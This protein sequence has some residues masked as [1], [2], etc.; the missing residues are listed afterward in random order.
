MENNQ[1]MVPKFSVKKV[2]VFFL[3]WGSYVVSCCRVF[4]LWT[5]SLPF[6]IGAMM[7]VG[8]AFCVSV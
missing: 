7:P 8:I 3:V 5:F 6:N 2:P 1:A 4:L